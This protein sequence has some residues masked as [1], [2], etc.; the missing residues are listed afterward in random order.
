[1]PCSGPPRRA[2]GRAALVATSGSPLPQVARRAG[3]SRPPGPNRYSGAIARVPASPHALSILAAGSHTG[4]HLQRVDRPGEPFGLLPRRKSGYVARARR[5]RIFLA[6]LIDG[7]AAGAA[8]PRPTTHSTSPYPTTLCPCPCRRPGTR[9]PPVHVTPRSLCARLPA[10]DAQLVRPVPAGDARAG[11]R[12]RRRRLA[13]AT[14]AAAALAGA[15]GAAPPAGA[16]RTAATSPPPPPVPPPTPPPP[17]SP[18]APSRRV[19]P[20]PSTSA[21]SPPPP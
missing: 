17:P 12:P 1:M 18:P 11:G 15:Y 7:S 5:S 14:L 10:A 20:P 19:E 8:A 3:A 2:H 21:P 6:K 4:R 16:T 13:A 9:A